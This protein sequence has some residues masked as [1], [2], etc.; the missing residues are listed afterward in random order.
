M[1]NALKNLSWSILTETAKLRN[2]KS[3]QA[4]RFLNNHILE[5]FL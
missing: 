2:L 5:V 4:C 1:P 3:Q